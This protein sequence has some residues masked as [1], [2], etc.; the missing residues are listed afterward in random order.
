MP[1]N[2]RQHMLNDHKSCIIDSI[3][4]V[5]RTIGRIERYVNE[6]EMDKV[7]TCAI[8]LVEQSKDLHRIIPPSLE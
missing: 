4:D 3:N 7:R 6:N 2:A 8:N 5:K 1:D